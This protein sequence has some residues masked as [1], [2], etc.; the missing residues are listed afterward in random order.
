MID[1]SMW[2]AYAE[3]RAENATY[4]Y[5]PAHFERK[6]EK[7]YREGNARALCRA[8]RV[9]QQCLEYALE[10]AESHGIWGGLNELERALLLRRR[11]RAEA[12]AAAAEAAE[13]AEAA[14]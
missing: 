12:E 1:I 4:F 2:R 3:C 13:A 5:A 10:V 14:C 6:P 9:R 11:R 8:C 7:D